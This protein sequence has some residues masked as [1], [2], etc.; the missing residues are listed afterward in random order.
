MHQ[1]FSEVATKFLLDMCS[2]EIC[3]YWLRDVPCFTNIEHF[4]LALHSLQ[5]MPR[6]VLY[7]SNGKIGKN[8]CSW[9]K[10]NL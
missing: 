8:G 5:F 10:D 3:V 6:F 2:K 7:H 4:S 1:I 9:K